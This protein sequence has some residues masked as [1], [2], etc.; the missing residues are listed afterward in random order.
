[1]P[2]AYGV[3]QNGS[4]VAEPQH[5]MYGRGEKYYGA[6]SPYVSYQPSA[7]Y[8]MYGSAERIPQAGSFVA[9]PQ[10]G[11][12]GRGGASYTAAPQYASYQPGA[13]YSMYGSA[14]P[15][16]SY[17]QTYASA[18][19][20]YTPSYQQYSMPS[21]ASFTQYEQ[22]AQPYSYQPTQSSYAM[23]QQSSF[24]GYPQFQFFKEAAPGP[25]AF[26]HPN[27]TGPVN[28]APTDD[29]MH[30]H[31]PVE[32]HQ[33]KAKPTGAVDHGASA[34]G[35]AKQF[36]KPNA[37]TSQRPPQAAKKSSKKKQGC[38]SCGGV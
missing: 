36:K 7:E 23:P 37:S 19:A 18:Q 24:T 2:A 34:P 28:H 8:G 29:R 1:M 38:C 32:Q 25:D 30:A 22:P 35:Q 5:G 31:V 16:F 20:P 12:Y 13:E 3:P 10:Y 6:A 21:T 17:G 11:G 4:F 9:D 26:S 33:A 14:P 15:Q 27:P